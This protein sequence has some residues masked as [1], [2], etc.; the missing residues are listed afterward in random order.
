M[1]RLISAALFS[2]AVP[3]SVAGQIRLVSDFTDSAKSRGPMH[4]HWNIV[5][6]ISPLDGAVT[7]PSDQTGVCVVRP[8]GGKALDGRKLIEED[9]YKWDGTRYSYDWSPLHQQIRNVLAS[10]RL[11]QLVLDNPSWA[12]L[13]GV[14]LGGM[15]EVNTYGNAYPP[16]DPEAWHAY[17]KAMMAELIATY[18]RREVEAWR[19][20][21]GREIG[22]P[23]HWRA[24]KEAFFS[25]FRNTEK[26]V[27]EMLPGAKVGTHFLWASSPNSFGPDFVKWCLQSGA[28]YDFIGISFYPFYHQPGRVDLDRVYRIDVAP[29][30][31][32]KEWNREARLEI[33]E[34]ALIKSLNSS[35][36]D[37]E[38]APSPHQ[39]AFAILMGRMMNERGLRDIFRW[40]SG[41]SPAVIALKQTKGN[42]YYTS[43][44]LGTPRG[45]G[46]MV[47]GLFS[48]KPGGM[49]FDLFAASYNAN[50]EAST[51]E[52]VR[53]Q[54]DVPAPPGTGFL[55]RLGHYQKA[56]GTLEWLDWKRGVTEP[57]TASGPFSTF[58]IDADLDAFSF[59]AAEVVVEH[60]NTILARRDSR[61]RLSL[62]ASQRMD[63]GPLIQ[64]RNTCGSG[65]GRCMYSIDGSFLERVDLP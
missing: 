2:L 51:P 35:G 45:Q 20:C 60:A 39:N 46:N 6:R 48:K 11:H 40:G 14:D 62:A 63:G 26:A 10:G 56:S 37:F 50:P 13:R 5:N 38:S 61:G 43:S 49:K 59:L 31:E 32:L 23:G 27:R 8:L 52:S 53:L 17:I 25:H 21:V 34:F 4:D 28:R 24:G 33:H 64:L 15:P 12:F 30:L 22:T 29:I 7:L 65:S 44:S 18:G 3:L 57:T 54:A 41:L 9:T 58:G 55:Y 19:F 36:N 1:K 42:I 16:N 47:H